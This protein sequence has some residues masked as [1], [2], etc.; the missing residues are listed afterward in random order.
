MPWPTIFQF[1]IMQKFRSEINF[2]M[3]FK[4][5]PLSNY[6]ICS[7]SIIK[8]CIWSLKITFE[9]IYKSNPSLVDPIITLQTKLNLSKRHSTSTNEITN[10]PNEIQILKITFNLCKSHS[11]FANGI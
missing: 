5:I 6:Q 9:N 7:N 4:N 8:F 10:L 1:L 11:S 3:I 2:T